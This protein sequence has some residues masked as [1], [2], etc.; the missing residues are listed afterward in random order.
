I[1]FNMTK[2]LKNPEGYTVPASKEESRLSGLPTKSHYSSSGPEFKR[3]LFNFGGQSPLILY[4]LRMHE[5]AGIS[6]ASRQVK[7][8]LTEILKEPDP[9]TPP[10][11]TYCDIL[12][13]AKRQ[14]ANN[15]KDFRM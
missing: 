13:E 15:Q 2:I 8:K 7:I 11:P 14:F 6:K 1:D 3:V 9:I 12:K 10:A 4:Y 5:L